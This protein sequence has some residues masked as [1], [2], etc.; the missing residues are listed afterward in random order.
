MK[1]IMGLSQR[2]YVFRRHSHKN[3]FSKKKKKTKKKKKEEEERTRRKRAAAL[4]RRPRRRM[5]RERDYYYECRLYLFIKYSDV[6][7]FLIDWSHM[8]PPKKFV[9]PLCTTNIYLRLKLWKDF[10]CTQKTQATFFDVVRQ[11]ERER[12]ARARVR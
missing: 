11:S 2:R 9:S 3:R 7:I 4:F 6:S 10:G 1:D 5:W 8:T 12:E